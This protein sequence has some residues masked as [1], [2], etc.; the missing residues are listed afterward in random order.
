MIDETSIMEDKKMIGDN[1]NIGE[2]ICKVKFDEPI[3]TNSPIALPFPQT[4]K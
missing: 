4:L 1:D 3:E 2:D